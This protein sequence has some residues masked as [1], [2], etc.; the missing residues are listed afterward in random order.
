MSVVNRPAVR[1]TIALALVAIV[2]SRFDLGA[3]GARLAATDLRLAAPAVAGLVAVHLLGAWTWRRLQDR[4]VG[5][6][7]AWPATVRL[8]YAAQAVG[9]LTPGNLGADVYRVVAADAGAGR[10]RLALPIVV[11]R[12]TS[13][14]ALLVLGAVGVIALMPG[15]VPIDAG[16]A[17]AVLV[18]VGAIAAALGAWA[19]RGQ[20]IVTRPI[21]SWA[22]LDG[23][24]LGLAFHAVSLGLGLG[25][26]VAV[27]PAAA[28]RPLEVLA[29]LA[30]ARL[31]LA[32]PL[33][34]NGL[35]IQ[36]GA[37]ALLFVQLGL[38]P[39]VALA[40]SLLNRVAL[41]I[42]V[43]AGAIALAYGSSGGWRGDRRAT[44]SPSQ[45]VA[46]VAQ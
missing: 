6:R 27:D 32:V 23:F 22:I 14:G 46:G 7:L 39:D 17:G 30:V 38:A 1:W 5:I 45:D 15:R 35:G 4:L 29:A 19:R 43:V 16:T 20:R 10:A 40:A 34:P 37:L 41:V 31:S 13:I 25:L 8:Y 28:A 21:S 36:E 42:T 2:L 9:S 26:V 24:G 33:S 12:L 3:V 11:Q 44:G 18:I